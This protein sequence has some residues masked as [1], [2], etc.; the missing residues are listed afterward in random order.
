M[1]WGFL[2]VVFVVSMAVGAAVGT[3][4]RRQVSGSPR[5]RG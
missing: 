4:K 1:Y 5:E 3:R 2:A